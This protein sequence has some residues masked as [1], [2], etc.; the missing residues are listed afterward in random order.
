[1]VIDKG[2]CVIAADNCGV[3]VLPAADAMLSFPCHQ[4]CLPMNGVYLFENLNFDAPAK[5][6]TMPEEEANDRPVAM[7]SLRVG[8]QSAEAAP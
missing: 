7:P 5:D 8:D 3:E 6:V 2:V 4:L 1:M